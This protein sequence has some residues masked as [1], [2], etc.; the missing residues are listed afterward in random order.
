MFEQLLDASKASI[1]PHPDWCSSI[2]YLTPELASQMSAQSLGMMF[3]DH[4]IV[5]LP[6][7]QAQ[8]QSVWVD[9][10]GRIT[11]D[12]II[13]Q[14]SVVECHGKVAFFGRFLLPQCLVDLH[15]SSLVQGKQQAVSKHST[16]HNLL[17]HLY[18]DTGHGLNLL[19]LSDCAHQIGQPIAVRYVS[20]T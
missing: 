18:S 13:D 14:D 5:I 19:D 12:S 15:F 3:T 4:H 8:R 1:I 20:C 10:S 2:C 9:S 16:I 7:H 11:L 17:D 6:G